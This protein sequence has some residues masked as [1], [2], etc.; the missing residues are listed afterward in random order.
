MKAP[1]WIPKVRKPFNPAFH[2]T[3]DAMTD[4]EKRWSFLLDMVIVFLVCAA[5]ASLA[6]CS[7]VDATSEPPGGTTETQQRPDPYARS[8]EDL[9]IV[10]DPETSCQYIGYIGHG[11]TPRMYI[12]K[13]GRYDHMGCR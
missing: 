2:D 9:P 3:W 8:G 7:R 13:V 11:V 1:R 12:T 5:A 10:V 6:G 4:D